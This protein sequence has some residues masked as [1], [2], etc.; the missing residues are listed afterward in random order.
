MAPE[1]LSRAAD[2]GRS[3]VIAAGLLGALG[4]LIGAIGAHWLPDWLEGRMTDPER[5]A[6]RIS[7]ADTAVR[8][9]LIHSVA[10]LSLF[11]A[12]NSLG[13][14]PA[15]IA[16]WLMIAGILLFSGS[17]YLL[18]LLDLPVLG[19]VTPLGG[20]AWIA[21]WSTIAIAAYRGRRSAVAG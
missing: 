13:M 6:R 8:Y 7:Q 12:R 17:L 14:R 1:Q 15:A 5:I 3:M 2:S 16:G 4:V 20:L 18:V 19:A 21:A 11:G 10:L 9:H